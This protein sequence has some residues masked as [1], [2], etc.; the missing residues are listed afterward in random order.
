MVVAE[1]LLGKVIVRSTGEGT[2]AVRID[3]VEAYLGPEDRACHTWGGRT[4]PRVRSMW[5][6]A[7]CAYVYLIY[8]LHHCLNV[9]TIGEGHGEAVLIRGGRIVEGGDLASQ[10]RGGPSDDLRLADGPGKLCQALAVTR[11]DDGADLCDP[12]SG[13]VI[14]D[15]GAVS[16]RV[17]RTPRIG[18]GSAGDAASWPLRFVL[19]ETSSSSR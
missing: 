3:E 6:E 1:E 9:V 8:G 17:E 16:T 11:D 15:D 18:I 19:R 5:G 2:V 13:L 10:R 12:K 4:T 14:L 7:G